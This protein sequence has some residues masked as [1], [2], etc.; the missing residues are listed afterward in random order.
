MWPIKLFNIIY[1][2]RL[3]R[4]SVCIRKP[5]RAF[6]I[7]YITNI[8]ARQAHI[9]RYLR[10]DVAKLPTL[11]APL[12]FVSEPQPRKNHTNLICSEPSLLTTFLSLI[13]KACLFSHARLVAIS[14][15]THSIC[16]SCVLSKNRTL[17]WTQHSGTQGH[18]KSSLSVSAEIKNGLYNNGEI[19]SEAY[20]DI[21]MANSSIST[22]PLWFD[23]SF[24]YHFCVHI[25]WR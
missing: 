14:S 22:T 20:K 16:M 12:R 9:S 24:P 4:S 11:A 13:I 7:I 5:P 21:A 2:H 1:Q 17:S 3:S 23:D 18:S 6:I 19:I 15:E 8:S 10:N 25:G